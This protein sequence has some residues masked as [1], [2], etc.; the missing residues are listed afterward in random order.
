MNPTDDVEPSGR[1]VS[2]SFQRS[3]ARAAAANGFAAAT[4]VEAIKC[5]AYGEDGDENHGGRAFLAP[6]F[7]SLR[8]VVSREIAVAD[9]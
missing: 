8:G 2:R 4:P 1:G 3:I 9:D 7:P 5:F 6:L